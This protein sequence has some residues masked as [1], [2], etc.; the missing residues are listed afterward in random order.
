MNPTHGTQKPA[1][2]SLS[3]IG[4][5]PRSQQLAKWLEFL[6][7]E[8]PQTNVQLVVRDMDGLLD[9]PLEGIL[10]VDADQLQAHDC[11]LLSRRVQRDGVRLWLY[12]DDPAR[13]VVAKLFRQTE[14]RWLSWPPDLELLQ[15]V[16]ATP[17]T[18][19]VGAAPLEAVRKLEKRAAELARTQ[20]PG[21]E[22]EFELHPT[23]PQAGSFGLEPGELQEIEAILRGEESPF[24]E[25]SDEDPEFDELLSAIE[26]EEG[27]EFDQSTLRS[28]SAPKPP[29]EPVR[30]PGQSIPPI[31]ESPSWFKD[32]VADL[33][34]HVQR[35]E[36]GLERALDEG[37]QVN[38]PFGEGSA[39][40]S[41]KLREISDEAARLG[42]FTR[43]LGFVAAPPGRGG[44]LFDLRTL[45]EEQLRSL[46]GEQDAPRFL[47]R[48]P[49]VLP[50]RSDKA[51]L[52][53][54]FD[55]L[56]F[57]ARSCTPAGDTLRIEASA[58]S[59]NGSP[60][61]DVSIRFPRGPL[62]GLETAVIERPYGLRRVLPQLGPNAIAAARGIFRGQGGEASLL[63]DG[64]QGLEWRISLPR[65]DPAT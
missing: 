48:I 46:A 61:I 10:L 31:T 18:S 16:L 41:S 53:Q 35:L 24:E 58:I 49:Q 6:A 57:M 12:G 59:H 30:E 25:A 45:L 26:E 27:E 4:Q 47:I 40:D 39:I 34:D 1:P 36:L 44:Q 38:G 64:P 20:S 8:S 23:R 2:L 22:P 62:Q 7:G 19:G 11:G 28:V 29:L 43:T 21:S 65:V 42:Q 63:I 37:I 13:A 55:A 14:A 56:L 33:A 54:A 51:L 17:T 32:Q 5:G 9:E 50:I 52:L 60:R 15:T 3:L